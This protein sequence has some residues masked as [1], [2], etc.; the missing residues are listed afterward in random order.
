[1]NPKDNLKS[2]LRICTIF[3]AIWLGGVIL[4]AILV[5]LAGGR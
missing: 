4:I 2:L 5:A 1:M 3:G